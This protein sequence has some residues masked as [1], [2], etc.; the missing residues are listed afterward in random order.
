MNR[1][2]QLAC[3]APTIF[4]LAVTLT[5]IVMVV[6][7]AVLANRWPAESQGWYIASTV[8]RLF[9]NLIMLALLANLGWLEVG[10]FLRLGSGQMWMV[11]PL[12]MAY[13]AAVSIYAMSGHL[14]FAVLEQSLPAGTALFL[15]LHALLEEVVFRGM[16]LVAFVKAWGSTTRGLLKGVAASSLIFVAQHLANVLGGY[17]PPVVLLQATGAFFLGIFLASLVLKSGSIYP[18]VVLH[19]VAN[20]VAFLALDANPAAASEPQAWLLQTVLM[21]PL[22]AIGIYLLHGIQ[23]NTR[24][25]VAKTGMA[26]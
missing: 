24:R 12:L 18:A 1:T 7:G 3:K 21:V 6:I 19:G 2:R 4:S 25:A 20:V 10:G 23:Q 15:L 9:S 14:S 8:A 11:A 22:A 13:A 5:Y 16:V 26:T 17:P